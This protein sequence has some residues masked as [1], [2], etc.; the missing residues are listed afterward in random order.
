MFNSLSRTDTSIQSLNRF[1]IIK[2]LPQAAERILVPKWQRHTTDTATDTWHSKECCSACCWY[3][4][5]PEH[6]KSCIIA[7]GCF[8]HDDFTKTVASM[9]RLYHVTHYL[10]R[11]LMSPAYIF[12][13]LQIL[14]LLAA[15][16][17]QLQSGLVLAIGRSPVR[18]PQ[19][20]HVC[21][22]LLT[23]M[24][25]SWGAKRFSQRCWAL[26]DGSAFT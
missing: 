19:F 16:E 21:S 22:S 25:A 14:F 20:S 6:Q 23:L 8:V 18:F 3:S 9:E 10:H 7:P 2:R 11:A 12:C 1:V 4:I 17:R 26:V 24:T 15:P 5:I 13:T